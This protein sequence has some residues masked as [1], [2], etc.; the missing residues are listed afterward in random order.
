MGTCASIP[1]H[2]HSETIEDVQDVAAGDDKDS[3]H[4]SSTSGSSEKGNNNN[5]IIE[6]S[7][8]ETIIFFSKQERRIMLPSSST[9]SIDSKVL[10]PSSVILHSEDGKHFSK[11]INIP[12]NQI[13]VIKVMSPQN[14]E[15]L[16]IG[17]FSK[18]ELDG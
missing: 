18:K 10:K 9:S 16:V 17:S 15:V 8:V 7:A 12:V 5:N 3:I 13:P 14:Q 4:V 2:H 11:E 1:D 6:A